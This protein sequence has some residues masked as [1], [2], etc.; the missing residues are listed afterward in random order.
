MNSYIEG[1]KEDINKNRLAHSIRVMETAIDLADRYGLD[2]KKAKI[3]GLLHDCAKY[4][5][6][7]K[8]LQQVDDFDIILDGDTQ[9]NTA[10]IHADLGAY[11]AKHKYKVLDEEILDAI[12]YH[13]T[14]RN[15]MT[16]LDKIIYLAD[17]IEPERNF[18]GVD[19]IRDI[20][21]KDLDRGLLE[22]LDSSIVFLL[23]KKSLIH[24]Y[25]IYARNSLIYRG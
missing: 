15:H 1:L 12:K 8:I 23:N 10:L 11:I 9:K 22:A 13:T 19:K 2:K 18:P 6:L 3:A 21:K 14:G 16:E 20:V 25:T 4:D 24:P 7:D 17:M 5:S